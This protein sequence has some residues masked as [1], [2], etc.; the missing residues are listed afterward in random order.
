MTD[1]LDKPASRWI[2]LTRKMAPKIYNAPWGRSLRFVSMFCVVLGFIIPTAVYYFDKRGPVNWLPVTGLYW[3]MMLVAALFVI[4]GYSVDSGALLVRRLLWTTRL[5]LPGLQSAEF[6]PGVMRGSL[7][8]WGNGGMLSITGWYR[9]RTLGN[10]RA[11]V[12][13]LNRTVVLRFEK[14]A[15]VISPENP[16]Q[17]LAETSPAAIRRS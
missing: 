6:M 17:F 12:T 15:V 1:I 10:Y 5:P 8:L 4:R 14:R 2:V 13:D 3:G 7:R 9:N 16:E 11:F